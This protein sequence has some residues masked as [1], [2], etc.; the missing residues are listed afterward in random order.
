MITNLAGFALFT[1]ILLVS[2][3]SVSAEERIVP[4]LSEPIQPIPVDGSLDPDKVALG[5]L[6]FNDNRLS[7]DDSLSCA[8]C[9]KQES[10]GDDGMMTGISREKS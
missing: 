8:S 2:H 5:A 7:K 4:A 1:A 9:H 10:G 6:L 3:N